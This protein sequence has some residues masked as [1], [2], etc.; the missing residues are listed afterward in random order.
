M[1]LPYPFPFWVVAQGRIQKVWL[2]G[3]A[4]QK[5]EVE[6]ASWIECRRREDQD[7]DGVGCGKGCPL[8][9]VE[10]AVSPP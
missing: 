8:P 7:A 2:G 9:T 1:S 3:G 5:A 6:R 10:G 4:N